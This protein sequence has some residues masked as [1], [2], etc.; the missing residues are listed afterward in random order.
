MTPSF[1]IR[2]Y[3]AADLPACAALFQRV[4]HETFPEDDPATYAAATFAG[5]TAGEC[6][7][8]AQVGAQIVGL[9]SLWPSGPFLHF[10]M[11][12]ARWRGR[13]IGTALMDAVVRAAGASADLKCRVGNTAAQRFYEAAGW[14]EVSRDLECAEPYIRYRL[15]RS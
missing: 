1:S 12:E 4:M 2:P 14:Q 13:G 15:T 5:H 11:V 9:A 3:T 8:V 10:L 6:L 7:W